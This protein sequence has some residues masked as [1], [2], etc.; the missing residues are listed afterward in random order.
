MLLAEPQ[1]R[2]MTPEEYLRMERASEYRHEYFRGEVT[3]MTGA[4]REH[5]LI[6]MSISAALYGQLRKRP[7]EVYANDMRVKVSATGLY[8]YPD[9]VVVCGNPQFEDEHVDTLLNPTVLI[10]VLSASTEDYDRGKKFARYRRLDSLRDYLLVAQDHMHVEQYT[11]QPDGA[12]RFSEAE[13]P[14]AKIALAAI[15]CELALEEIYEK[16]KFESRDQ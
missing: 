12:W 11:R 3:D 6:V 15:D 7:C 8:T 2:L 4:S 5:N 1:T 9:L 10:E 13:Q 14:E 16:I